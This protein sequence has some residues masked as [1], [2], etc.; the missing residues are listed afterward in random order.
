MTCSATARRWFS[1]F[2]LCAFVSRVNRRT[3]IRVVRF[4][5]FMGMFSRFIYLNGVK[6]A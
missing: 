4:I 3:C 5:H 1:S 2:V 6:G